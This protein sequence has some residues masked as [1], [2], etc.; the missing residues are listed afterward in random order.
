MIT[1][2]NTSWRW[3]KP[4]YL[5]PQEINSIWRTVERKHLGGYS[6]VNEPGFDPHK[7]VRFC[8]HLSPSNKARSIE[9]L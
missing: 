6:V 2:E 8:F 7:E 4:S 3:N 9:L 1:E 5:V